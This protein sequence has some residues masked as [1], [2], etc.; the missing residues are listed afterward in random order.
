MPDDEKITVTL[1][2]ADSSSADRQDYRIV[3]SPVVSIDETTGTFKL[4]VLDNEDIGDEMLVFMATIAGEDKYGEVPD[5][6]NLVAITLVDATDVKIEP[7]ETDEGYAAVNKAREEAAGANGL[8]TPG[9]T[10]TL[11]AEDLFDWPATTTSVVLSNA[12][13]ADV[14]I[15]TA[16]TS[17]D[18]LTITAES[19]G[20][21]EVTV[22]GT[23]VAEASSFEGSQTISSFASVKFP[24]TV[25]PHTITAMSDMDVQAAA[26]AAIAKAADEAASE[27]WEPNGA[28]AM[29]PV[30]E[31]FDVPDEVTPI[32]TAESSDMGDVEAG[33]SSDK[34]YVTLMPK[35]A[36]MATITVTVVDRE[37]GTVTDVEFEAM[38]MAP[39]A[40][41]AKTQAEVDAVFMKAGADMLMAGGADVMVSMDD[42]FTVAPGVEPTYSAD[43]DMPA[44][45]EASDSGMTATLK[46][47]TAGEA[48]ITVTAFDSAS[49]TGVTVSSMVT[50]DSESLV[51][52][53]EMPDDVMDGNI[54]EGKSYD[55]KVMANRAVTEDTEVMILRDRAASYA[56][57]DD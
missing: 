55:I 36:G 41:V 29:V 11:N 34:M 46:P 51:V 50:V 8:W 57:D 28:T 48:T 32:Y 53:L 31:L 4:D 2:L 44:V 26:D 54:V 6:M 1:S 47:L 39:A 18:V 35:S 22:T 21:T 14:E 9:E 3:G 24:V 52:T 33:I 27:Q 20:M 7:K 5:E 56:D 40:I 45:I 38:V 15:V 30:S 49:G 16:R 12:V 19:A 10:M 17:N 23:V 42:L 43:S 37:G 25:D 13:S